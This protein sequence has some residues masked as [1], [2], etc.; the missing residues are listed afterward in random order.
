MAH[1]VSISTSARRHSGAENSHMLTDNKPKATRMSF[2]QVQFELPIKVP[3]PQAK[4]QQLRRHPCDDC[5][6]V[7]IQMQS[8]PNRKRAGTSFHLRFLST[9]LGL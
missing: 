6:N 9:L 2:N 8:R 4:F 5:N 7:Q 1:R 3:I